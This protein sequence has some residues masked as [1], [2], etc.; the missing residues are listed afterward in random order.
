MLMIVFSRQGRE[1]DHEGTSLLEHEA[2]PHPGPETQNHPAKIKLLKQRATIPHHH[3]CPYNSSK[4]QNGHLKSTLCRDAEMVL[5]GR[6]LSHH[7]G[8]AG[9]YTN[10]HNTAGME[11]DLSKSRAPANGITPASASWLW[12]CI[13]HVCKHTTEVEGPQ[14]GSYPLVVRGPVD[15]WNH[16]LILCKSLPQLF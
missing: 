11:G 13:I 10:Q 3:H 1:R 15:A 2:L 16:T 7:S 6:R 12:P 4:H 8:A 14:R 9:G 5:V